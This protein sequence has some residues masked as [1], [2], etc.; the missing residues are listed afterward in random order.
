MKTKPQTV[1]LV[2]TIAVAVLALLNVN[3]ALAQS[4]IPREETWVTNGIINAI[5]T[6]P[7][8]VYIGG[9]FNYV[10]PST[11]YGIPL[12]LLSGMPLA[13]FPKVNGFVSVCVP[14]GSGGWFIGG[15][16]NKVGNFTRKYIAHILADGLVD[17]NWNPN[18]S[19]GNYTGVGALVVSGS[20][21]YVGG[22]FTSIGGQ[23]RN[24]IA[25]LNATTGAATDWNPNAD[26]SVDVLAISGSTV[27]AGGWFSHIGGQTRNYIAALDASTGAANDWNPCANDGIVTLTISG[28]TVYAGGWFL[29]ISGQMRNY[30]AAIDADSTGTATDWNP[31]ASRGDYT[32]PVF[33]IDVSGSTIYVG[34]KFNSI[35]GKERNNIA[36]L[37]AVTGAATDWNPN[38]SYGDNPDITSVCAIA[39][40][41]STIYV[42]GTFN[43]IGG[44]ERNNIAALD[45]VTGSATDW[46]PNT[47]CAYYYCPWVGTLAVSGST[48]YVGGWFVSIGGLTRNNIAALDATT[49]A[50]TAWNPNANGYIY[51]LA[52][53]GSTLY[54]AG[55]FTQIGG[56]TRNYIAALDTDT[57]TA[58]FWN[59]IASET[60]YALA[61]SGSTV[62]AG[63]GFNSIG[64]QMRNHIAAL[65]AATGVA[66]DWNPKANASINA[67]AVSGSTVYAGGYFTTIGGQTRNCIAALD[68]FTGNVTDWNPNANHGIDTLSIS[69]STVY[70]GGWFSHIGG[71]MRNYIAAIDTDS[72]GTAIDWNPNANAMVLAINASGQTVYVGGKFSSIGGQMRN[73]IAALDAATGIALDW[74]PNANG[75]VNAIAI[76]GSILYA[77]GG[78]SSIGGDTMRFCLARFGLGEISIIPSRGSY[79]PGDQ[80]PTRLVIN[81][82]EDKILTV[83]VTINIDPT[84]L[85]VANDPANPGKPLISIDGQF[86]HVIDPG[87]ISADKKTITIAAN[88]SE[89]LNGSA[90]HFA[91]ITF[92][93]LK[94]GLTEI[95]FMPAQGE[96]GTQAK[97]TSRVNIIETLNK[98]IYTTG[99]QLTGNIDGFDLPVE[100]FNSGTLSLQSTSS[101]TFGFWYHD[102]AV[103]AP[104]ADTLY[105]A[106]CAV[107]SD[108]TDPSKT[109]TFR[110]RY[111]SSN[112]MQGDFIQVNS[113]DNGEASPSSTTDKIYDLYFRPQY[114]A[115]GVN[116]TLS[117]DMI[118]IGNPTD[119]ANATL[120]LDYLQLD[121]IAIADLESTGYY[122]L[123]NFKSSQN[124]W[125]NRT[126]GSFDPPIYTYD[127]TEG[128]LIMEST[129]N[130]NTFGY[131]Q[132]NQTDVAIN[133]NVFYQLRV[134][135]AFDAEATKFNSAT[136]MP[137]MRLRMYDHPNNHVNASFQVPVWKRFEQP[138]SFATIATSQLTYQD[139]YAY[140]H[141][142]Q[143]I[144]PY[145]GI[146]IDM[147]NLD[148]NASPDAKIAINEVELST[149][150]IPTF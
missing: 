62:Y 113:N 60:V 115:V 23:P 102:D 86:S 124:N 116:G 136:S 66:T 96:S 74:N 45:A 133:H 21:I 10:G 101:N 50:A 57:G 13:K 111:N 7:D 65:D 44:K 11:G 99:W 53:S 129:N 100:N 49:G 25:A 85:E 67:L 26:N 141:N 143:G 36:A 107:K 56:Q 79:R 46:N 9:Y 88:S 149:F 20:T 47:N 14:D 73:C 69:G 34:G 94:N 98:A 6:T 109:P 104:T 118:N 80:I 122:K 35:G 112:F 43:S 77:V 76:S 28:S 146:A 145:L 18:A 95:T 93:V 31:N 64:G 30:I 148:E 41:G 24:N 3:G 142:K 32:A 147:I 84:M 54:A 81:T 59:P 82:V 131:W 15:R 119:A 16:F 51:A 120:Y 114:D 132:N 103:V 37:D 19:G 71:Q 138:Q 17:P 4:S 137:T 63:G 126:L 105:R 135:A 121:K 110:I 108:Q 22:E 5:A 27:Y 39:V 2:V 140:F 125:S 106:R 89:G 42:G 83:Q 150:L 92:N 90:V 8:T 72:T 139:Y 52:I 40:S 38:A 58:T 128:A 48:I 1:K 61:V 87:T 123:Y 144:G 75:V 68:V 127:N 55:A 130:T 134:K 117:F 78:F 70:A 97:N 91:D 12:D 33:I 29:H